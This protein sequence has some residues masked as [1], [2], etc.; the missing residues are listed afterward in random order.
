MNKVGKNSTCS[1]V[2]LAFSNDETSSFEAYKGKTIIITGANAGIGKPT[3]QYLAYYG[4]TVVLA[5]R[6]QK[7]AEKAITWIKNHPAAKNS[8]N[9]DSLEDRLKFIELDLNSFDSI[10]AFVQTFLSSNLPPLVCLINNAG[11]FMTETNKTEQGFDARFGVNHLGHFLLTKLLL[12][13]LREE[14]GEKKTRVINVSSKMH[15]G[16]LYT[17]KLDDMQNLKHS[18]VFPEG[19]VNGLVVSGKLYSSSKMCNV[20]FTQSLN[21]KEAE[22]GVISVAIH[23][24]VVATDQGYN[25]NSCMGWFVKRIGPLFLKSPDQGASCTLTG[26]FAPEDEVAGKYLFDSQVKE[27][28]KLSLGVVGKRNREALWELSEELCPDIL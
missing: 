19:N 11:I 24:G 16:E 3:A 21:E 7:K 23:P 27:S 14:A 1:E 4:A 9:P 10:K 5:C 22:N 26:V 2:L 18:L 17:D 8:E 15:A 25:Y 20:L 13:K 12:P 6:S 28:G